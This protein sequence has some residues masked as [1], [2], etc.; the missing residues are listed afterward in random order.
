[1]GCDFSG[2]RNGG[3]FVPRGHVA[4]QLSDTGAHYRNSYRYRC[5]YEQTLHCYSTKR[6]PGNGR[7]RLDE[8][9]IANFCKYTIAR[10]VP[11]VNGGETSGATGDRISM[12]ILAIIQRPSLSLPWTPHKLDDAGGFGFWASTPSS[13]NAPARFLGCFATLHHAREARCA[14]RQV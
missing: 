12:K 11:L 4:E 13:F 1:M 5:W 2:C 3:G 10:A 7:L 14:S 9:W 8:S 6:P